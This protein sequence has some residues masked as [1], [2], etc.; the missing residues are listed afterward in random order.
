MQ[1]EQIT[2]E[3]IVY[4]A[5]IDTETGEVVIL[6]EVGCVPVTDFDNFFQ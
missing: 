1:Q 3:G 6:V 5:I 2:I 4:D